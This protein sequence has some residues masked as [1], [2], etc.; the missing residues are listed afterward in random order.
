MKKLLGLLHYSKKVVVPC[1]HLKNL[2]QN[3]TRKRAEILGL[4]LLAG[5]SDHLP[6]HVSALASVP[7]CLS[8]NGSTLSV[9]GEE[10][11]HLFFHT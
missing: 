10:A 9:Q 3:P 2:W 11:T 4:Q 7:M 5:V 6:C 8:R 1:P